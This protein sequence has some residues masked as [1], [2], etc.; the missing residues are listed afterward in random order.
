MV[1]KGKAI[2]D[3]ADIQRIQMVV[4]VLEDTLMV[5]VAVVDMGVLGNQAMMYG[6]TL[7]LKEEVLT[8]ILH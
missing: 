7:V 5:V 2:Q 1:I 3:P 4:A 8:V 6:E